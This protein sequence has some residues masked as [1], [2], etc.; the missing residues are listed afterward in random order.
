MHLNFN[1]ISFKKKFNYSIL[2]YDRCLCNTKSGT[3]H[4]KIV[5][6][7]S[8]HI[9]FK[10]TGSEHLCQQFGALLIDIKFVNYKLFV[11]FSKTV[12]NSHDNIFY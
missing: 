7:P 9:V 10:K 2:R 4:S 8:L 1:N 12:N 3:N 5:P 6:N 11:D